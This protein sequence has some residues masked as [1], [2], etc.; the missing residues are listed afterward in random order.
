MLQCKG[1]FVAP[2]PSQRAEARRI[3]REI[4]KIGFV[5]PGSLTERY[6]TCTHAGCHCHAVPPVLHGPYWYWTRKVANKTVSQ[7]LNAEQVAEYRP[8]IDNQRRLR[9]L[10]RELE[11]IGMSV[12]GDDPRTPR[13]RR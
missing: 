8:W 7:S 3:A 9:D 1:G 2:T 11:Q 6:L 13:R 4:S 12:L 10:L 5:L